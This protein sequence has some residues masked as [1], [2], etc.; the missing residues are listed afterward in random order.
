MRQS[1]DHFEPSTPNFPRRNQEE[2]RGKCLLDP[3]GE[4]WR[5]LLRPGLGET[6][7]GLDFPSNHGP[8]FPAPLFGPGIAARFYSSLLACTSATIN[9]H[10]ACTQVHTHYYCAGVRSHLPMEIFSPRKSR[11]RIVN[12]FFVSNSV[13]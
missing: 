3:P 6:P 11:R 10:L 5:R 8:F 12:R 7:S 2:G 4:G 1:V 13:V 9:T